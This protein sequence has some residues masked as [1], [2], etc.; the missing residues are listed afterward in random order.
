[1]VG[2]GCGGDEGERRHENDVERMH[3]ERLLCVCWGRGEWVVLQ[4][5]LY[6]CKY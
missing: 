1:M 2:W 6:S 5:E 4:G 3:A